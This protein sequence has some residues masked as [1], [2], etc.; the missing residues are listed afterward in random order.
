M[1]KTAEIRCKI[2]LSLDLELYPAATVAASGAGLSAASNGRSRRIKKGETP[3][4]AKSPIDIRNRRY[5]LPVAS[6]TK[7]ATSGETIAASAEP[8]FM[9]PEAVPEYFAAMS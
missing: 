9:M 8:V 7:P 1:H 2:A 4:G 5:Q 3:P 6:M